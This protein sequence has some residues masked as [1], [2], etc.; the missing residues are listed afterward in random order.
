[1]SETLVRILTLADAEQAAHI[2]IETFHDTYKDLLPPEQLSAMTSE[3][4]ILR[5]RDLIGVNKSGLILLGA[6][7]GG[8]LLAVSGAG[9]PREARGYDAELW[10]MNVPK[11]N[12]KRGLGRHLFHGSVERLLAEGRQ[13]MF[14]YCIDKNINALGFYEKMGGTVTDIRAERKGYTELLVFWEN[15]R[16]S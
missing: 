8:E 4:M 10:S 6:F 7:E 13:S 5:W 3:T 15:V 11:R 16:G 9:Q 2:Q 1:M 12:Q 14:L